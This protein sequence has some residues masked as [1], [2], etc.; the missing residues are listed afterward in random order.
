MPENRFER[1]FISANRALVF[2][3]MVVMT[4]LVFVNVVTRYVCTFSMRESARVICWDWTME[5]AC[6]LLW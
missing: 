5:S 6:L 2:I 3:M 1:C 4:T